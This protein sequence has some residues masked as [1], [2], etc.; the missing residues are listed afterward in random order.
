MFDA[1]TF[2]W[3]WHLIVK[4]FNPNIYFMFH[5]VKV[6]AVLLIET[7]L[8][9]RVSNEHFNK[10]TYTHKIFTYL[11][12]ILLFSFLNILCSTE[13]SSRIASATWKCIIC[14]QKSFDILCVMNVNWYVF[15]WKIKQL[16]SI[17]GL[18][19]KY[20]TTESIKKLNDICVNV[21]MPKRICSSQLNI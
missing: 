6:C 18:N 20:Y 4:S 8:P 12:T 21:H 9:T 5:Y 19:N 17:S 10:T 2:Y 16:F 14:W 13:S 15:N 11:T 7:F 1:D 3:I